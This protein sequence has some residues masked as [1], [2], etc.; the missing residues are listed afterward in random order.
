MPGGWKFK[1]WYVY[2]EDNKPFDIPDGWRFIKVIDQD[3]DRSSTDL[4]LLLQHDPGS[5]S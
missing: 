1:V 5:G 4:W 2:A 3:R